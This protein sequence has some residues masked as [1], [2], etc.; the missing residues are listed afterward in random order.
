MHKKLKRLR[1]GFE[2]AAIKEIMPNQVRKIIEQYACFRCNVIMKPDALDYQAE[3]AMEKLIKNCHT[4]FRLG[5]LA[6]SDTVDLRINREIDFARHKTKTSKVQA[7]ILTDFQFALDELLVNAFRGAAAAERE[8]MQKVAAC[9]M[10][11]NVAAAAAYRERGFVDRAKITESCAIVLQN[12]GRQMQNV[13]NAERDL[14]T[15]RN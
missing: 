8:K 13:A 4:D 7:G 12:L 2:P 3:A 15:S 9:A 1:P 5:V 14:T 10:R 11:S 6:L